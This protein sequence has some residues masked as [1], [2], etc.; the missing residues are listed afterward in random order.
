MFL[1][2]FGFIMMRLSISGFSAGIS[3]TRNI[4]DTYTPG[5]NVTVTLQINA[6]A[7]DAPFSVIIKETV[8]LGWSFVSASD[9]P[10]AIDDKSSVFLDTATGEIRW[11]LFDENG[12]QNKQLT[13]TLAIPSTESGL[14]TITG[15]YIYIDRQDTAYSETIP[16]NSFMPRPTSTPTLTYNPTATFT[17]TATPTATYTPTPTLT[18]TPL[19]TNTPT[20]TPT[21]TPSNTPTVTPTPLPLV[22]FTVKVRDVATFKNI[23]EAYLFYTLNGIDTYKLTDT[24]GNAKI[25]VPLGILHIRIVKAGFKTLETDITIDAKDGTVILDIEPSLDGPTETPLP[26]ATP[27]LTPVTITSPTPTATPTLSAN[28]IVTLVVVSR[29]RL[30]ELYGSERVAQLLGK[31]QK[32]M[33]HETVRGDIVDLDQN[34]ALNNLYKAWD[35]ANRSAAAGEDPGENTK[36]AN[37]V[38]EAVKGIIGNKRTDIK[39]AKVQYILFVGSDEIIPFYR[40]KTLARINRS[41]MNYLLKLENRLHP[42]ALALAEENILSDDYYANAISTWESKLKRE[43]NIKVTLPDELMTGRLAETPEDMMAVIDA[44]LERNGTIDFS[45]AMA[46]GSGDMVDGVEEAAKILEADYGDIYRLPDG[47]DDNMDLAMALNKKSPFNLLGLHGMHHKIYRSGETA[48][49]SVSFIK[50]NINNIRGTI[51]MNWGDHG[52]LNLD[53]RKSDPAR[54][55]DNLVSVFSSLGVGAY[56]GTTGFADS[57]KKSKGFTEQLGINFAQALVSGT[58][59]TTVGQAFRKA[60]QEYWINEDNGLANSNLTPEEVM[61]NISDDNKV[62]SGMVLYGM[63]MLR[64]TSMDAKSKLLRKEIAPEIIKKQ[65]FTPKAGG[66]AIQPV[67]LKLLLTGDFMKK[68]ETPA[69]LYYAYNG[70]TQTNINEPV[71]PK[72]TC[73]SGAQSFFPK[74]AV[75][76]SAKYDTIHNFDPVIEGGDWNSVQSEGEFNKQGFFPAVP[77]TVNTL[78]A[79]GN[80]PPLQKFV[81]VAGQYNKDTKTERLYTEARYTT[82]STG[83][84]TDITPP[85]LN[86]PT[87]NVVGEQ[88]TVTMQGLD[89]NGDALYR[90][91]LL[92]TDGQGE[93]KSIDL[94]QSSPNTK[95]WS[96]VFTLKPDMMFFLQAVD[97]LGNVAYL[98]NQGHYY[99]VKPSQQEPKWNAVDFASMQ[100]LQATG[101]NAADMQVA[102]VPAD[103]AFD[104]ATDGIGLKAILQPGQ[105]ALLL[106]AAPVSSSNGL[107]ELKTSVRA[108]SNQIQLGLV[109][110]AVPET[111]PDGS[112]GNVNPTGNEVPVNKWGEMDL[113]YDCPVKNYYPAIQ[114]VL[115][116]EA[117]SAETVYF[118]NLRYGDYV[119]KASNP[120]AMAFDTTFDTINNALDTLNPFIFLDPSFNKG[121][122]ALTSGQSK[123]GVSFTLLPNVMNQVSRIGGF[124]AAPP[125]IPSTVEA[126]LSVK[127][128]SADDDGMFALAILDGEQ[129]IAYYI[130]ASHLPLN[131][132]KQIR[133][134]GNF[135]DPGQLVGPIVVIQH[136]GSGKAGKIIIDD[137]SVIWN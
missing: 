97:I 17:F 132:Y 92:W 100:K 33:A 14:K 63:P 57:S 38:V 1:G 79:Q 23:S 83:N 129:T 95:E 90:V 9:T 3:I 116:K 128:E 22:N 62:L 36:K 26:M 12:M 117:A 113:V 122:I 125:P 19:P 110:I 15:T 29:S 89:K 127:K 120:V 37:A 99:L 75:L 53:R 47:G 48:A 137:L 112:L 56:L 80:L 28:D 76:E 8:P 84:P 27:T 46:A 94:K 44:Y 131:Q 105:G 118:D 103:N 59:S 70:I 87:V 4:P 34:T 39:Y 2:I 66:E 133:V 10:L 71:Q 60:K 30:E 81:F 41:E 130:K 64:V 42:E 61:Q 35:A 13:Y 101:F 135:S 77:F 50:T 78:P 93:W 106:S 123:Q 111:G 51:V 55:Y 6:V 108:T 82:Y 134:G 91:V 85:T 68:S 109:A 45:K 7:N 115:P 32:L 98:D 67:E 5:Q 54:V 25:S 86:E 126:S 96:A 31:L 20:L 40:T 69:G 121:E 43:S 11:F 102:E 74:G 24:F 136:A 88:A 52:G 65:K 107:V 49:L 124:F 114:F 104:H 72:Y 119:S 21:I 58:A 73:Y 16:Q 18:K